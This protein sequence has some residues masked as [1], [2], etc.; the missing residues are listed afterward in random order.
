MQLW[1]YCLLVT[2]RSL[3]M[4]RTLSAPIIRSTIY[5]NHNWWFWELVSTISTRSTKYSIPTNKQHKFLIT[6]PITN[7]ITNQQNRRNWC[8]NRVNCLSSSCKRDC[9]CR[10][11]C[12]SSHLLST[13]SRNI[14]YPRSSKI[15]QPTLDVLTGY[16]SS[17]PMTCTSG[18]F[19]SFQYS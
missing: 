1:K 3:Y 2:A 10:G 18:C 15:Y 13:S 19:Y 16:I 4:F 6:T 5:T 9:T 7:S 8:R 14:L 17:R 12:R 11:I